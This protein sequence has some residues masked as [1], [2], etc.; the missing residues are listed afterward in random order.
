MNENNLPIEN[1]REQSYAGASNMSGKYK[2]VKI[3]LQKQQPL[4]YYT[5]CGARRGN[6]IAQAVG[7]SVAIKDELTLINEI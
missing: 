7:T 5:Y 6:L 1:L 2:G 3:L 4:T